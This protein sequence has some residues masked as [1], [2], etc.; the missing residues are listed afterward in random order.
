M[1]VDVSGNGGMRTYGSDQVA[2]DITGC[3]HVL[4]LVAVNKDQ[5]SQCQGEAS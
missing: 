1:G 3:S 5:G 4:R 2:S